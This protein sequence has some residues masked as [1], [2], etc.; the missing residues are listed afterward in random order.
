MPTGK[1]DALGRAG[2]ITTDGHNGHFARSGMK[3]AFPVLFVILVGVGCHG[4]PIRTEST[5]HMA[6]PL[7]TKVKAD[8]P[9][10]VSDAGPVRPIVV[11]MGTGPDRVDILDV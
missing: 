2:P 1:P 8:F 7:E 10:P 5:I 11:Q 6:G 3:T 9:S 4:A